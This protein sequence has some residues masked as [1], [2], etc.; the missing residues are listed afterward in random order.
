MCPTDE[1]AIIDFISGCRRQ[2]KLVSRAPT[3][4]RVINK[5]DGIIDL[6]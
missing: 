6:W 1:Y 2:I 3:H 5:F 4:D